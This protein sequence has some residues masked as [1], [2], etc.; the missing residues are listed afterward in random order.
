MTTLDD[1][2]VNYALEEESWLKWCNCLC[3]N[4]T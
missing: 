2:L 1:L 4:S 3:L